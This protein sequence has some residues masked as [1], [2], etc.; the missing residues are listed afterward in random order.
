[1]LRFYFDGSLTRGVFSFNKIENIQHYEVILLLGS[2]L[3]CGNVL[4]TGM[5]AM[6]L[7]RFARIVFLGGVL[8]Q[9]VISLILVKMNC[10]M[11]IKG[12]CDRAASSLRS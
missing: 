11:M 3:G 9:V 8:M 5:K 7:R 2:V 6:M 4:C 12:S 10:G 1:L